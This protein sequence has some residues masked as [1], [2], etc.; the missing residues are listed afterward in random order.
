M[1]KLVC[2]LLLLCLLLTGCRNVEPAPPVQEPI[3]VISVTATPATAVSPAPT[4][5]PLPTDTPSPIPTDTPAPT[6]MDDEARLWA[7]IDTMTT[8][9]KIG[10]LCMFGFSGTDSVSDEF[11]AIM[12]AYH[13]GSVI[14]YGQNIKRTDKDGGFS[15][16]KKLTDSVSAAN[17]TGIPLL[18]S[19]D[20]E[21]G[22]V[23]R[24]HWKTTLDSARTL[25]KKDNMDKARSEFAYIGEGLLSA[26]INVD[27]APA[28]DVCKNP[29]EHFMGKRI[30]SSNA[31]IVSDIGVACIQGLHESGVLSIIKHFPGH[32]ATNTD[33]HDTIPKVEKSL[34]SL[35]MYELVPFK[36][37][38][39][40]G[41]DGVMV[42][43]ILYTSIDS[44]NVA[45][46]SDSFIWG[47]LRDEYGFG[48]IVMSDDFRMAGIR[49]Q[50]SLDKAA[51][52][53]IEAGGDLILCGANHTYQQKILDGLYA[54]VQ[55]GTITEDRLNE[56]V[57]RILEAKE[58]VTDWVAV[59]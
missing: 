41:A 20:V 48:G 37:A 32:G 44:D 19:T 12:D 7:F 27:L 18:I 49:K 9:E 3:Q 26:G 55:D 31:D 43:H 2:G 6:P 47:L 11:A 50:R 52:R 42:A 51:V 39:L 58:R 30:I 45:S 53:F 22:T 14:L 24:F 34:D 16:C 33:S 28:L 1:R 36:D 10:Q 21:G 8:E 56:S 46:Q 4:D 13:I 54:A 40:N 23:T 17:H 5:T 57:F 29:D 25:G 35:R 15:R 59:P 38:L